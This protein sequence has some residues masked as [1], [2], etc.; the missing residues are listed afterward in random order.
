VAIDGKTLR[1][2]FG[3]AQ[4][5]LVSASEQGRP[6]DGKSNEIT[7]IPALLETLSLTNGIVTPW[8]ARRRSPTGSWNEAPITGWCSTQ[9]GVPGGEGVGTVLLTAPRRYS[10]PST[11]VRRRVFVCPE[12]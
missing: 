4:V 9:Q 5:H 2:S 1:R 3:R 11:T 8:A 6:A 7:A 12:A 10:T